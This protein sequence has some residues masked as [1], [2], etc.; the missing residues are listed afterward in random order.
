MTERNIKKEENEKLL[1]KLQ[2]VTGMKKGK[3]GEAGNNQE[4]KYIASDLS[5]SPADSYPV[6]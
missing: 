2:Q 5:G 4:I 6:S 1:I 3:R